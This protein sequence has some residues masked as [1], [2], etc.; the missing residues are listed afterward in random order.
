MCH[1]FDGFEV[2]R[3]KPHDETPGPRGPS[4]SRSAAGGNL[5]GAIQGLEALQALRLTLG[6]VFIPN[7]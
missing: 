7:T 4:S 6:V 1:I 5:A 3:G 2:L